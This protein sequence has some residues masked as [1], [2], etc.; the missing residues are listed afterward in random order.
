MV[1]INKI[2]TTITLLIIV[3]VLAFVYVWYGLRQAGVQPVVV[4]EPQS[5]DTDPVP[6]APPMTEEE[7]QAMV[8]RLDELEPMTT[9]E[10]IRL[11]ERLN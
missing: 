2:V 11:L 6:N 3:L 7:E 8:I 10:A 5:V 4:T 9:E 1:G